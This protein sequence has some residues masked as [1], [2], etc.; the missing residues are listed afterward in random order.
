MSA[1]QPA[2]LGA[3]GRAGSAQEAASDP[4]AAISQPLLIG[5]AEEGAE[6][7]S[8]RDVAGNRDGFMRPFASMVRAKRVF[9]IGGLSLV[10]E[11]G[12]VNDWYRNDA[13]RAEALDLIEQRGLRD[14][15]D[16]LGDKDFAGSIF[17]KNDLRAFFQ[18]IPSVARQ[19]ASDPPDRPSPRMIRR[20]YPLRLRKAFEFLFLTEAIL[21]YRF[22][23]EETKVRFERVTGVK[24]RSPDD[25]AAIWGHM[26]IEPLV[27]TID[28]LPR[29]PDIARIMQGQLP[30]EFVAQSGQR[31]GALYWA[32]RGVPGSYRTARAAA[33]ACDGFYGPSAAPTIAHAI[34]PT[35][36][37]RRLDLLQNPTGG[38]GIMSVENIVLL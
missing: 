33:Q 23:M 25:A 38:A 24:V 20:E 19:G 17:G 9:A 16:R 1:A 13:N 10:I 28:P 14:T 30:L 34:D 3:R 32:L 35:A 36:M 37:D 4:F 27:Y 7:I 26:W 31:E 12:L 5:S 29:Q 8:W 15:L 18:N 22:R 11:C 6:A 2:S 21:R